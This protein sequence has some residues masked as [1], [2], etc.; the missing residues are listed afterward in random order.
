MLGDLRQLLAGA[1]VH[2]TIDSYRAAIVEENALGKATASTRLESWKK[3]RTLYG[4]DPRITVFRCFRKLWEESAAGRPLLALLLACA[5]DPIL[6]SSAPV[7]L[8]SREGE[9]VGPQDFAKV[10]AEIA[11]DRFSPTNLKAIGNRLCSSWTQSGHLTGGTVRTRTHPTVSPD[12]VVYALFLGRLTGIRG[13]LLF[14]S[15][16]AKLLDPPPETLYRLAAV[17]AQRGWIDLRRAGAVMEV[18]FPKLLTR[19]EQ[20]AV[21]EP[22]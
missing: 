20:E 8:E 3:L 17:A 18:R 5:R 6:R 15:F 19:E 11:P 13:Q 2:A 21:G 16:W 9:L 14:T 22:N 12:A 1:P 4:L 10:T 7:I